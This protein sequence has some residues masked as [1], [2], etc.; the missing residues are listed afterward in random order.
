MALNKAP[1]QR[2]SPNR[3]LKQFIEKWNLQPEAYATVMLHS[4]FK[5]LSRTIVKPE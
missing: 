4:Q 1:A 3:V 5:K 2:V